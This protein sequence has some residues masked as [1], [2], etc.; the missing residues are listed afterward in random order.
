MSARSFAALPLAGFIAAAPAIAIAQ[1]QAP[2]QDRWPAPTQQLEQRGPGAIRAAPAPAPEPATPAPAPGPT[3]APE[4]AAAAPAP[5]AAAPAAQRKKTAAKPAQPPGEKPAEPA[6]RDARPPAVPAHTVACTGLFAR[7]SS[8]AALANAF[9]PKNITFTEVEGGS[10]GT[11]TVG[12]VLFPND[13]KRRLEVLWENE[14]ARTDLFRIAINGKS[15]WT[16]PKGLRLGLALAAV[17][18]I[19][20]K[21]FRLRGLDPEG[22]T[23]A[24][25]WQEGALASLP[26]GC[27][28]GIRFAVDPKASESAR[29]VASGEDFLSNDPG[30]LA[31]K[32]TVAEILFGYSD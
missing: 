3:A 20:G 29:A 16:G 8:H 24:I 2:L 11:K 4:P 7:N 5:A 12:S 18:K 23:A 1:A 14:D 21:P 9:S 10:D 13:P 25:D 19:N 6:K 30:M 15:T 28:I 27:D 17:E 31:V 22:F 32:P 26:G